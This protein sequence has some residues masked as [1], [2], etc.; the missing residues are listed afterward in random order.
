[1][2]TT[3][4]PDWRILAECF[5]MVHETIERELVKHPAL[6]GRRPSPPPPIPATPLPVLPMVATSAAVYATRLAVLLE[7]AYRGEEGVPAAVA[8]DP[9]PS[10]PAM[11]A[12]LE[13]MIEHLPRLDGA[14][15]AAYM[16]VCTRAVHMMGLLLRDVYLARLR[17]ACPYRNPFLVLRKEGLDM[18]R[19]RLFGSVLDLL[20]LA[21]TVMQTFAREWQWVHLTESSPG[22]VPAAREW[23]PL[24]PELYQLCPQL[25]SILPPEPLT[26]LQRFRRG[27]PPFSDEEDD[28]A[29]PRPPCVDAELWE[30]AGHGRCPSPVLAP[31]REPVWVIPG[32]DGV[33]AIVP[34][35]PRARPKAPP[36]Q[37]ADVTTECKGSSGLEEATPRGEREGSPVASLGSGGTPVPAEDSSRGSG[38]AVVPAHDSSMGGLVA[39]VLPQAR[40]AVRALGQEGAEQLAH[41]IVI[42][43]LQ[44][45]VDEAEARVAH[46]RRVIARLTQ[47]VRGL[48]CDVEELVLPV[49]G[50]SA[51][52]TG[53]VSVSPQGASMPIVGGKCGVIPR[54]DDPPPSRSRGRGRPADATPD[55]LH[56]LEGGERLF[57]SR[58]ETVETSQ[59]EGEDRVAILEARLLE[60]QTTITQQQEQ[61]NRLMALASQ[62]LERD[63]VGERRDTSDPFSPRSASE[64][65]KRSVEVAPTALAQEFAALQLK[66]ERKKES[67]RRLKHLFPWCKDVLVTHDRATTIQSVLP[68]LYGPALYTSG[69]SPQAVDDV[70]A[71]FQRFSLPPLLHEQA[72]PRVRF[73][74]VVALGAVLHRWGGSGRRAD[75][76]TCRV[77]DFQPLREG[78]DKQLASVNLLMVTTAPTEQQRK[79][80]ATMA[81]FR[82]A[83]L[84]MAFVMGLFLGPRV[85]YEL[86]LSIR[87]L[88]ERGMRSPSLMPVSVACHLLDQL[89]GMVVEAIYALAC[90]REPMDVGTDAL[91]S[92]EVEAYV[93]RGWLREGQEETGPT[94]II[95][96]TSTYLTIW[97]TEPCQAAALT[98][99]GLASALEF[100]GMER[101][102]RVPPQGGPTGGL[103]GDAPTSIVS[104]R[105]NG[106]AY[107]PR[108][109]Y[110]E[111]EV[112]LGRKAGE[113][114]VCFRHLAQVGC[115]TK[116]CPLQHLPLAASALRQRCQA[117]ALLQA[118][119][120]HHG[121]IR[122]VG[123][124]PGKAGGVR[125]PVASEH[126]SSSS[127][128]EDN[129]PCPLG[130]RSTGGVEVQVPYLSY[131]PHCYPKAPLHD[132]RSAP[133]DDQVQRPPT[134]HP[135]AAPRPFLSSSLLGHQPP[136]MSR[137]GGQLFHVT[138]PDSSGRFQV[139]VGPWVFRG[140][141]LGQSFL[142]EGQPVANACVVLTW[143]AALE[144]APADLFHHLLDGAYAV[145][146]SMGP[147]TAMATPT[148]VLVRS[149]IHDVA[150]SVH[151]GHALDSLVLL[152][153]P[154]SVL[155][156]R[157]VV[158][159][160]YEGSE[161]AVDVVRGRDAD[162]ATATVAFCLQR[163]GD[164]GHMMPM[165]AATPCALP[166]FLRW[167]ASQHLPVRHLV[168]SG[169]RQLLAEDFSGPSVV[170]RDHELCDVCHSPRAPLPTPPPALR[171]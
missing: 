14:E 56:T 154:P 140:Q 79:P 23:E 118:V 5:T 40:D 24:M 157:V 91:T 141:D 80:P 100:M 131:I 123:L 165:T 126:D 169:W 89:V 132:A 146:R 32:K 18:V 8:P 55:S 66:Q 113:P 28:D 10:H 49:G 130:G 16:V 12:A 59:D 94:F 159:V 122:G 71:M 97:Y 151:V 75:I 161:M 48:A 160:H 111:A 20:A 46:Y 17:G 163:R 104:Q 168:A 110:Q 152:Y 148:S 149:L 88:Y 52:G 47:V 51:G 162:D 136:S 112:A 65:A 106:K 133:I 116:G 44:Q 61:I 1:M 72:T 167:L 139:T 158:L 107:I 90:G 38:G 27:Y 166:A 103:S 63:T 82:D 30:A 120:D 50:K 143:A 77:S 137:L 35:H 153:L 93:H 105:P 101:P 171:L 96:P 29:I 135:D 109:V 108:S 150:A 134:T 54:G 33:P 6:H 37:P 13:E 67:T 21:C 144:M 42:A 36:A 39:A 58:G 69:G 83:A 68:S 3:W 4:A 155:A 99:G 119:F 84:A 45:R 53:G 156:S 125:S 81:E 85:E 7:E 114:P 19:A 117:S 142:W 78:E 138:S 124:P 121:G 145:D 127:E 76:M 43:R 25:A 128:E 34:M 147:P 41:E 70:L 170:W 164:P 9:F 86:H 102:A 60:Q 95:R 129:L 2:T 62:V 87:T 11:V 74:P 115:T 26:P 92:A 31:C 73:N 22:P 15:E 57:E 64:E 98:K